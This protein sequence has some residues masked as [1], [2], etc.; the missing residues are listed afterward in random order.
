[1]KILL[2]IYKILYTIENNFNYEQN[3]MKNANK[4]K[5]QKYSKNL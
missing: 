5:R 4:N 1:M 2:G 3:L